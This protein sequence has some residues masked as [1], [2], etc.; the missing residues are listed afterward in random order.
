MATRMP[1]RVWRG[2]SASRLSG[3]FWLGLLLSWLCFRFGW[4]WG[5]APPL[6]PPFFFFFF[7]AASF[8]SFLL[9]PSFSSP[10]L[11]FRQRATG[12]GQRAVGGY[13]IVSKGYLRG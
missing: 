13:G 6:R 7:W 10:D 9:C 5:G 8:F 11:F 2:M 1:A 3:R 12:Y 4:L